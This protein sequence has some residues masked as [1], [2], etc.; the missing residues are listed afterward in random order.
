MKCH[1]HTFNLIK[2]MS[3]YH[4]HWLLWVLHQLG[5]CVFYRERNHSDKER[6]KESLLWEKK[7]L[8]SG[9]HLV[10]CQPCELWFFYLFIT[11][12]FKDQLILLVGEPIFL[13]LKISWDYADIQFTLGSCGLSQLMRYSETALQCRVLWT[14][15][16]QAR[17]KDYLKDLHQTLCGSSQGMQRILMAF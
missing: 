17:H 7:S 16:I 2:A 1:S 3:P 12:Y 10:W 8:I 4:S 9:R 14:K 6:E 15:A 5:L 13:N 11:F